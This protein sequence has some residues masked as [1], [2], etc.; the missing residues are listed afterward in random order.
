M[1]GVVHPVK[2]DLQKTLLSMMLGRKTGV[3][4]T[5]AVRTRQ[6]TLDSRSDNR[7]PTPQLT[8]LQ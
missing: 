4:I 7:P 6:C 8:A 2:L 1:C 5:A 3:M